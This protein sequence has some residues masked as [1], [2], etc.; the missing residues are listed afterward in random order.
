MVK[1]REPYQQAYYPPIPTAST[2]FM[3][4]FLVWQFIR[5][6]IINF[7]IFKLLMKSHR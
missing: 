1:N 5:F 4:Q 3:R 7:K 2:R 6:W